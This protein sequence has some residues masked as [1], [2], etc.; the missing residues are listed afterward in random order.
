MHM[1]RKKQ[2]SHWE[3]IKKKKINGVFGC[4]RKVRKK[5]E[6]GKKESEKWEFFRLSSWRECERKSGKKE[7]SVFY[8]FY[9]TLY[10]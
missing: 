9:F 6:E 5:K 2:S 10:I 1:M 8:N 4:E 3:N 7:E